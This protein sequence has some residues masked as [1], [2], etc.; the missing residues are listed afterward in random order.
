MNEKEN[1]TIQKIMNMMEIFTEWIIK[2]EENHKWK[3]ENEV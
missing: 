3:S 2:L 1:D